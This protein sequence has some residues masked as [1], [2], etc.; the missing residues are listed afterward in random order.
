MEKSKFERRDQLAYD[1]ARLRK[2]LEGKSDELQN[3]NQV[4]ND[5]SGTLKTRSEFEYLTFQEKAAFLKNGG[6]IV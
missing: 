1:V 3:V 5:D 4:C 6:T 2:E